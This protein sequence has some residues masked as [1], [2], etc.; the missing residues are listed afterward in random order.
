M[1]ASPVSQSYKLYHALKDNEVEVRFIAYPSA[2]TS[3]VIR[4]TSAM[5]SGA[6]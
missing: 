6:G 2:G 5:C 3:R 1:N 4:S